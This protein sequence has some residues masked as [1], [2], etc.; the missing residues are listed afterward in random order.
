MNKTR[1]FVLTSLLVFIVSCGKQAESPSGDAS[2][3]DQ[4]V[5]PAMTKEAVYEQAKE[6]YSGSKGTVDKAKAFELFNKGAGMGDGNAMF[7]LGVMYETGE[8]GEQ[9][10]QKALEWFEKSDKAGCGAAAEWITKMKKKM[11]KK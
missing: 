4:A 1:V 2:G 5:Q 6:Y 11:K 7:F 3:K 9:N 8:A 10:D